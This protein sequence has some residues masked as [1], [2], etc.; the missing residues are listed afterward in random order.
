M[1]N[2]MEIIGCV[3]YLCSSCMSFGSAVSNLGSSASRKY[4]VATGIQDLVAL[5]IFF[6][7]ALVYHHV[8]A[9]QQEWIS[10]PKILA[11]DLTGRIKGKSGGLWWQPQ[12]SMWWISVAYMSGS[13]VAWAGAV[14]GLSETVAFQ[15]SDRY[16]Q[17]GKKNKIIYMYTNRQTDGQTDRWTDSILNRQWGRV[18]TTT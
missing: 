14:F 12:D 7:D 17:A 13:L 11:G 3:V 18:I 4:D 10:P 15:K 6:V 8:Y 16:T 1:L 9:R 2:V 5:S